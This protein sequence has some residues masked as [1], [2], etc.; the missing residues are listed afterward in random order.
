MG[1][2]LTYVRAFV[3]FGSQGN[4]KN[5]TMMM[6]MILM[7]RSVGR[8]CSFISRPRRPKII[9]QTVLIKARLGLLAYAYC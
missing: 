9:I 8:E 6:K 2:W 5:I 4:I 1:E 3:F 7:G